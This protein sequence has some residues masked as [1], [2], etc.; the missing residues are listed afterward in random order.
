MTRSGLRRTMIGAALTVALS[1][2]ALAPASA[3]S[4]PVVSWQTTITEGASYVYGQVPAAPTCTAT[5][6]LV[7]APCVV[8]GYATTVGAHTVTAW[9]DGTATTSVLT[10]TVTGWT[11]KGFGKPV[12]MTGVNKVKAGATVPFKFKVYEG[13][14]KAKSAG[15]VASF[16]TQQYDCTT[17][18][19]IGTPVPVASS[20]K[21]FTLRYFDGAFHQNWKTPKPAKAAKV[22]V[23]GKKPAAATVCYA[24]TLTTQ[25]ASTLTANFLLK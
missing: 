17:M 20:K 14:A 22:K 13:A 10:Y 3:A 25:D 24:V 11:L 19:A 8:D 1:T 5:V 7:A 12:K 9:V 21:G 23:K 15:V 2:F 6:D 4:D 18:A 16:T